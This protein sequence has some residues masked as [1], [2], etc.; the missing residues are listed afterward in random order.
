MANLRT[1]PSP[2]TKHRICTATDCMALRRTVPKGKHAHTKRMHASNGGWVAADPTQCWRTL[3]TK[4][5]HFD[6]IATGSTP[7][8]VASAATSSE[9]FRITTKHTRTHSE[10]SLPRCKPQ[11]NNQKSILWSLLCWCNADENVANHV[12]WC[13]LVLIYFHVLLPS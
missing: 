3:H 9:L 5:C 11:Q 4:E 1:G 13:K 6:S 10:Q 8:Q 7:L 12:K 2:P